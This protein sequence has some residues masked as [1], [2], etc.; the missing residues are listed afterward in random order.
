MLDLSNLHADAAAECA[1]M[2][3]QCDHVGSTVNLQSRYKAEVAR[4]RFSS[5]ER[6]GLLM[7]VLLFDVYGCSKQGR[8]Y[9]VAPN[10]VRLYQVGEGCTLSTAS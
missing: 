8:Y 7:F 9:F 3:A 1:S 5:L 10:S 2:L 6:C 4:K